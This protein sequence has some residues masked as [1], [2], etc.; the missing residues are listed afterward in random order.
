MQT[1]SY[2]SY[3]EAKA[4]MAHFAKQGRR[5]VFKDVVTGGMRDVNA[6]FEILVESP[7]TY[8]H[9]VRRGVRE[10]AS[11]LPRF[12]AWV[13]MIAALVILVA[14]FI[15]WIVANGGQALQII[16]IGGLGTLAAL[17]AAVLW[18]ITL[19]DL[20]AKYREKRNPDHPT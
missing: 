19:S 10:Q 16:L 14:L 7:V 6:G 17:L 5:A 20:S 12:I 3:D 15:D 11:R 1:Y 18:S 4:A 8:E 13:F 9:E 2:S